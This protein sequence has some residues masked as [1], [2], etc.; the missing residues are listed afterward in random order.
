[1]SKTFSFSDMKFLRNSP[2]WCPITGNSVGNDTPRI[3]NDLILECTDTPVIYHKF[4]ET[5]GFTAYSEDGYTVPGNTTNYLLDLQDD[6]E[7]DVSG[8]VRLTLG[9]SHEGRDI[10]AFRLGPVDRKHFVVTAVVH[11]N[12]TDGL[13]GS[14]KGFEILC[15]HPD[16]QEL[17]NNFT[18]FFIPCCNPDGFYH[19]T[20]MCAYQGP[21]PSGV[22]KGVNLNRVWPNFWTEYAPSISESK[23][24]TVLGCPEAQAMYT[25]ITT[26]NGGSPV[27]IA[28]LLDQHSTVGD[29]ARYQSRDRS[30]KNYDEQDWFSIW[31]DWNIYRIQRATQSKRINEDNMPDLHINYFRSRYVPHFHSWISVRTKAENGGIGAIAMVS[32]FNKV[33]YIKITS[34]IETYASACN[35]NMDYVI[36]CAKVMQ[37]SC[38]TYKDAVL[39]EHEQGNNQATNSEYETWN[40]KTAPEESASYRPSYWSSTRSVVTRQTRNDKHTKYHGTC[41]KASPEL[42]V[43]L[44]SNSTVGP[45]NYHDIQKY[46]GDSSKCMIVSDFTTG[47]KFFELDQN[48]ATGTLTEL[49]ADASLPNDQQK[50]FIGCN[51]TKVV[52]L[53]LGTSGEN[54]KVVSYSSSGSYTRSLETTYTAPR[55]N[56]AVAF[57]DSNLGYVIGGNNGSALVRTV[58]E[59]NRTTYAVSEIGTNLLPTADENCEAVYCSGGNLDGNVVVVGGSTVDS[60][61]LRVTT[62]DVGTPS[63]DEVSLDISGTTLPDALIGHALY[64]DGINTIWI[65][66]GENPSDNSVYNGVWTI[67]WSGSAWSITEKALAGGIGDDLDPVD[68]SGL[69]Y[70][71]EKWSR[72]RSCRIT[73]ADDGTNRVI[74]LG[75]VKE[76]SETGLP[77]PGP[78]NSFFVHDIIDSVIHKPQDSTFGYVRIG[79]AF[80]TGGSYDKVSTSWSL[81]SEDGA[82]SSY[83][84]VN[85]APGDTGN[86]VIT[87]RRARTYYM[88]PPCWWFRD[89]GS[90]DLS[91]GRPDRTE[92]QWRCYMRIYRHGQAACIDSPMVQTGTLWPSSWSPAGLPRETETAYWENVLDPR[93]LRLSITWLPFASFLCLSADT[94]LL[95]VTDG[96]RKLELWAIKGDS[97]ERCY[98][99]NYVYGPQDPKLELRCYDDLGAYE[100]CSVFIYWGGY[101]KETARERFDTPVTINIWQHPK[102]GRGLVVNNYGAIGKAY[103]P[104][105]FD[106]S[107]WGSQASL[108]LLGGGYWSEPISQIID[109]K[110]ISQNAIQDTNGA[111]LMGERDPTFG[112]VN[113]ENCFKYVENFT[114]ANSTNLGNLWDITHQTGNGWDISSNKAVCSGTG[115][116]KWDA[117]PN[118]KNSAIIGNV[119]IN[120]DDCKVGF[121][122]RLNWT[123]A[124]EGKLHGYLGYLYVDALGDSYLKIDSINSSSG[125]EVRTS[126]A[127]GA[128][129]YSKGDFV[130]LTFECVDDDLT[131]TLEDLEGTS[132]GSITITDTTHYLPEAFGINGECSGVGTVEIDEIFS[133]P[134]KSTK[135][136][137]TE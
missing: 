99:R 69:G 65:Y 134:R 110:W 3:I 24:A 106:S 44:T 98:V 90:L 75:G 84:R 132:L 136:R 25:W 30:F 55:Y 76:D 123:L 89:Q 127:S 124:V 64:Y 40:K 130:V 16:F 121:F 88:Q 26:G 111:L 9:T 18:L 37:G 49:F 117:I 109:K 60:G 95:R 23:G 81:K 93:W 21:H 97:D 5:Q 101:V 91:V 27:P 62:I 119:K 113:E 7:A 80:S 104:G 114:R 112:K 77:D 82:L 122:S 13:T 102:Y 1:M 50:R 59:V 29:G 68:Y 53:D 43:E 79:T 128:C 67:T 11:G 36:S 108:Y 47:S 14:F 33:D 56:S 133:E 46:L 20:R 19:N 71:S 12:E 28:F 85:N 105:K 34:D 131:L 129:T 54:M 10:D 2:A 17:R 126:L 6:L 51:L 94:C 96:T 57:D 31:A 86:G 4:D 107:D 58:L 73:D 61:Y 45:N 92:D 116:E 103:I 78:Y 66:G 100:S 32:E 15:T 63:A 42:N 87:T 38:F 72:W 70:W 120:D 74:L 115:Q 41:L 8:I 35:Y 135:I 22:D 39:I 83:V 48:K 118:I 125:S 52:V 137:I